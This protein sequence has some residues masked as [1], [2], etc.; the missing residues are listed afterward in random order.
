MSLDAI[1]CRRSHTPLPRNVL[2]PTA[3]ALLL[4]ITVSRASAGQDTL[5]V[6]ADNPPVW[7]SDLRLEERVRVGAL[8]G[9][10]FE[11]F[12]D[13][14]GVVADSRGTMYVGDDQALAVRMF[15]ADGSYRGTL[16]REGDGPGEFR[17]VNGVALL[18]GDRVIV[19]DTRRARAIVYAPDGTFDSEF[20][21]F[22]GLFSVDVTFQTDTL[23]HTYVRALDRSKMGPPDP[24]GVVDEWHEIWI[25]HG[26]GGDVLDSIPVPQEDA[27]GPAM[28]FTT[29]SGPRYPY[30]VETLSAISPAGYLIWGRNDQYAFHRSLPDRRIVRVSKTDDRPEVSP[31]ERRE[32]E[33]I[34]AHLERRNRSEDYPPPPDRKP[35]FRSLSADIQ[36][37]VWIQR[38]TEWTHRYEYS[39]QELEARGDRPTLELRESQTFDV[40]EPEGR[41]LGTVRLPPGSQLAFARDDQVW[42]VVE[43]ALGEQYVVRY[44]LVGGGSGSRE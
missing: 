29:P 33:A 17:A 2:L 22:S 28:T 6:V 26:P 12:G 25:R 44:A 32:W 31:E 43:G 24:D 36:G 13:V 18:P 8:E 9:E 16:G 5:T 14:E 27:E 3:L 41:L 23:G 21:L 7:G 38:Y 42:A 35:Y 1:C 19:Q 10:G 11:V 30:T 39:P 34:L 15:D 20:Q 37:R 4:L 40:F